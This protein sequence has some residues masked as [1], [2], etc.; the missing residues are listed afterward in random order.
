MRYTRRLTV[1]GLRITIVLAAALSLYA[2]GEADDISDRPR[3][4]FALW[5]DT[6]Y[7][8]DQIPKI[9]ALTAD[10]NASKVAFSVFDGDI[11]SGSALCTNNVFSEAIDRFNAFSAPMIY[12]PG[13]NEWTDCHRI[14]NGGYN[15]LERL[16]YLRR[17]MFASPDSFGQRT[18]PLEHQG[19]LGGLYAENTR[20]AYGNVVFVGLNIPGSNNN[21][22]NGPDC[23]KKSVRTLADCADVNLEYAARLAQSIGNAFHNWAERDSQSSIKNS[24]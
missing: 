12:V 9:A 10:I 18:L 14:N 2:V 16:D 22:V 7:S 15:N 5:G 24:L 11:K 6:P 13:D 20:W 17:T 3:F 4:T 1:F 23:T 21:K 8:P 19:P